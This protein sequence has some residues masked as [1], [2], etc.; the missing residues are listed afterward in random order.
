MSADSLPRRPKAATF[1]VEE[2][3]D[4]TRRGRVR[5]PE[6]QR[7]LR[8]KAAQVI[9]LFDSIRRGFP[10]GELLMDLRPA[11]AGTIRLGP[12][13][14]DVE[15]RSD[16]LWIIDGQQRL[17]SLYVAL[18]REEPKPAG[19][20]FAIWYD[21]ATRTFHR[22]RGGV[23]AESWLPMNVVLDSAK[24][25][26]F[27][28]RYLNRDREDWF[29]EAVQ[30]GK[31]VREFQLPGYIIDGAE[32]AT[33]RTIFTRCNGKGVSMQESEVFQALYTSE[34]NSPVTRAVQRLED[35]DF[36]S[37]NENLFVRCLRILEGDFRDS[38]T[39]RLVA[40]LSGDVVERTET[41]L[42]GAI[43][44]LREAAIHH[45][46][47]LPYTTP[48][49]L[50]V[51]WVDRFGDVE[52]AEAQLAG[53]WVWRGMVTGAL[54]TSS[55]AVIA[56]HCKIID[57]AEDSEAAIIEMIQRLPSNHQSIA[58]MATK[59]D[60]REELDRSMSQQRAA[61]KMLLL[62]LEARRA[63]SPDPPPPLV[64][65]GRPT[66]QSLLPFMPKKGTDIVVADPGRLVN[67]DTINP[68]PFAVDE[69]SMRCLREG[70][71]EGFR[72]ARG[73]HLRT[74]LT[75]FLDGRLGTPDQ[76]RPTVGRMGRAKD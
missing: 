51:K 12:L 43:G 41:A 36:G 13:S 18:A 20:D 24:L 30:L 66:Y 9:D 5:I 23:V 14:I 45:V 48:L 60:P 46:D 11:A 58:E 73:E 37:I 63:A 17:T 72:E 74:L 4:D 1:S 47:R 40:G 22:Y 39:E 26:K 10:V 2:L 21:L 31:S 62:A 64:R 32:E 56:P 44:V 29:D 65:D 3:V 76:L 50:L 6:F 15:S 19:D 55:N 70:N 52:P 54:D 28:N 49:L 67:N 25:L 33:V 38:D 8:W 34:G 35:A 42:R 57:A 59:H 71:I 7:P 16:A 69:P 61:A 75:D 27:A 68:T 53:R